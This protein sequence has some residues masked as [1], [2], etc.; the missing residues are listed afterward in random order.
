MSERRR[1]HVCASPAGALY[2]SGGG[3]ARR[4]DG[5]VGTTTHGP[6]IAR[7]FLLSAAKARSQQGRHKR[8]I[9]FEGGGAALIAQRTGAGP[10]RC[11]LCKGSL[12]PPL[13]RKHRRGAGGVQRRD[14]RLRYGGPLLYRPLCNATACRRRGPCSGS[15]S[16]GSTAP[17]CSP[18]R[19]SGPRRS[20]TASSC[21]GTSVAR[22]P[23]TS[24]ASPTPRRCA[25][26]R[27][28]RCRR[29]APRS[30]RR[31]GSSRRASRTASARTRR[32]GPPRHLT[33]A[34]AGGA[35]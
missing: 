34:A 35:T 11:A 18:L 28:R 19:Q 15:A 10:S 7:C 4:P 5:L 12:T 24:R 20:T 8:I 21:R 16:S 9:P 13:H 31:R 29:S 26:G 3:L 25:A 27:G 2:R 22:R 33:P 1:R 30:R 17:R 23:M 6:R 32:R 14:T